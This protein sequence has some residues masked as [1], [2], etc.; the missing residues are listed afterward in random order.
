MYGD[1]IGTLWIWT[2]YWFVEVIA[3]T[4]LK[5]VLVWSPEGSV[6]VLSSF[7]LVFIIIII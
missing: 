2:Y 3:L 1:L 4:T 5:K 7:L 6:L